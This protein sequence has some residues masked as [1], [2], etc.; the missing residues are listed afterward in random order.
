MT[1][2]NNIF[3]W[4]VANWDSLA[5]RAEHWT[6]TKTTPNPVSVQIARRFNMTEHDAAKIARDA[7][8][9]VAINRA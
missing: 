7:A 1:D 6:H 9:Y 3:K 4:A 2:K 8:L 5:K